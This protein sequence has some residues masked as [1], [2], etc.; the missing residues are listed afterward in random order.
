MKTYKEKV[1]QALNKVN[2]QRRER[3]L[4]WEDVVQA[5]RECLK[6]DVGTVSG[7]TVARSY[8]WQAIRTCVEVTR[9]DKLL[10][11]DI[12]LAD[13]H[14]KGA[15]APRW[16][17]ERVLVSRRVAW[18]WVREIDRAYAN[19]KKAQEEQDRRTKAENAMKFR[20][21][22]LMEDTSFLGCTAVTMNHSLEAGNCEPETS[23]IAK[24]YFPGQPS[25]L[26]IDLLRVI[27][28]KE[29]HLTPY[30]LRAV[31]R[32]IVETFGKAA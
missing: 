25:V 11:V 17:I 14:R 12:G 18:T 26:A 28:D 24:T 31:R 10:K 3:T 2:G 21:D 27:R 16:G 9:I 30:A 23:R 15:S 8:K 4:Q 22:Q 1:E 19:L 7:E 29:P 32:A 5:I 20:I 13:A 6:K